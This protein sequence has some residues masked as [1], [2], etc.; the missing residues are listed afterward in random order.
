MMTHAGSCTVP[1]GTILAANA[2]IAMMTYGIGVPAVNPLHSR[3]PPPNCEQD[4][5]DEQGGK[6]AG[7]YC[8]GSTTAPEI[9]LFCDLRGPARTIKVIGIDNAIDA[10]TVDIVDRFFAISD[11]IAVGVGV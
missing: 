8:I 7:T 11:T 9:Q 5:R 4:K 3:S 1:N 6:S 2:A 10:I